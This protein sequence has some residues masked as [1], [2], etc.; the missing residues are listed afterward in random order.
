MS[1]KSLCDLRDIFSLQ[2]FVSMSAKCFQ[3]K[4]LKAMET[5][6]GEQM[7]GSGKM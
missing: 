6:T 4:A 1:R 7:R 2:F 3:L 5:L